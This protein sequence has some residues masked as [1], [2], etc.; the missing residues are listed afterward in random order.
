MKQLSLE[1]LERRIEAI[2]IALA[3][4]QPGR[5]SKDWR[6]AIGMF[7]G[8]DFMKQ[9]DE[10]GRRIREAGREEARSGGTRDDA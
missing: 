10:E 3:A 2:E 4:E 1:S 5:T 8:S 7:A 9:V 6:K